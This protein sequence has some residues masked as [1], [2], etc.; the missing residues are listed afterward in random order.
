VD[1]GNSPRAQTWSTSQQHIQ[2]VEKARYHHHENRQPNRVK[3]D[4]E[5]GGQVATSSV[6]VNY[7]CTLKISGSQL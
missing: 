4:A 6:H 3:Y 7:S 1:R 2:H 5:G